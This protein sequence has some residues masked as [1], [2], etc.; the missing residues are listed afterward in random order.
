MMLSR[1]F[2]FLGLFSLLVS[3]DVLVM[4]METG[5]DMYL[6]TRGFVCISRYVFVGLAIVVK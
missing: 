3:T 6:V 5:C 4:L 2:V 1:V